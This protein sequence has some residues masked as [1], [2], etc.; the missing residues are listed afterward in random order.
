MGAK[1]SP[2]KKTSSQSLYR[3]LAEF[4]YHIRKYL[5]FTD[6]AAK[7]AGL[8]PRQY[9]L[10]LAVSGMPADVE[11][12]V[13]ALAHQLRTRHHST[14]ELVDRAERNG[15]VKRSRNGNFVLVQLTNRGE[16]MLAQAVDERLREL[17]IAGPLLVKALQDLL[18]NETAPTKQR[19]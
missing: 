10:L 13:S 6:Q 18:K 16:R 19:D 9:Q 17:H 4:R 11:P 5:H 8:E 12:T 15:L 2:T 1:Q 14:V 3:A 7:A